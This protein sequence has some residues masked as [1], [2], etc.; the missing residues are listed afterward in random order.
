[1]YKMWVLKGYILICFMK[2]NFSLLERCYFILFLLKWIW[3]IKKL[4]IL[5]IL[6]FDIKV[7]FDWLK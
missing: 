4:Y 7:I 1:M 6:I 2:F 3:K 5:I